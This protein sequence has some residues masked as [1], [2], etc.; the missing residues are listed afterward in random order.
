[1]RLIMHF[2][3]FIF[4]FCGLACAQDSKIDS[5]D[6]I[7]STPQNTESSTKD[8]KDSKQDSIEST[9]QDFTKQDSKD[10]KDL[11][12]VSTESTKKDSIKTES[13]TK[14]QKKPSRFRIFMDKHFPVDS[15]TQEEYDA[16]TL[17]RTKYEKL[18]SKALPMSFKFYEPWYYLPAYTSFSPTYD[19][20]RLTRTEMKAQLSSR[21][22]F[23]ND[24][25]CKFCALSFDLNLKLYLQSYNGDESSPL[26]DFDLSPGLSFIYKR[27]LE[28]NGGRGGVITWISVGYIHI[29]NG[30]K[31]IIEPDIRQGSAQWA[32][33][34][35]AVRSK[36]LDRAFV[37][38][39]Y[40]YKDLNVR[41]R[42]WGYP[43]IVAF[44]GADTNGDIARYMGY[45]DVR[46]SYAYKRN[47]FELY[48]NNIFGNYFSSDFWRWKGQ[49]E[50]GYSFALSRQ[51]ALY[52]QYLVGHGDSLYEYSLFT[53]RL[54][55]G[56][57]LR[58]W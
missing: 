54:G 17:P 11:P 2:V 38:V 1:M 19:D 53:H 50:L 26:R 16:I 30:E 5:K 37:E 58:D 22:E 56:F 39:N 8:S 25:I 57:R 32:I 14:K 9:P 4:I 12:K 24:M 3:F 41:L 47:L 49:L 31:E 34:K 36:S 35:N 42:G 52:V 15:K 18:D 43:D 6:T 48:M 13:T 40:R 28:I 46:V 27:P 51:V 7:E 45:G 29:S 23:L 44:D 20:S 10:S 33:A 55:V 21:L